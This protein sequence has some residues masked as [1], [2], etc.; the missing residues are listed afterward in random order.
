MS[1]ALHVLALAPAA[2]LALSASATAQYS[3][4][5]NQ[6]PQGSPGNSSFSE[7]LDFSDID[8]DGDMDALFADGGD[9][10]NDRNRIW[11]NQGGLQGGTI[12]FFTD[13][14]GAR[15]PTGGDTSRDVDFVDIDNDGD[16][17]VY[18]S[19]T[20][21][22]SN[23]G[24]RFW[25]NQG[26]MQ[27]GTAGFF[28]DETS[29]R[30]LN[31]GLNNGSSLLSSVASNLAITSGTFQGSFVDWSCDCVFG[32]VDGDGFNDLIHTTYGGVFGGDAPSR[33]FLNDGTGHFEE[34]NPT[35]FQL[36][37]TDIF[38]GDP[39]LWCEG[40]HVN[41]TN[42]TN[43]T[44]CDIS[45][46]PLGV[47]IGDI[48]LDWDI[49]ILQGARNETPRL[50]TN[51]LVETGSVG[52][53]DITSSSLPSATGGGNYEQEI[54]DFD[55]DNDLDLYGLN[56][57]GLSDIT[58]RNNLG[59][60]WG[61][62]VTLSGSGSDDNEGDFLD[63]N[64][65]G[66]LDIFVGN[67]GGSNRLYENDGPP[68]WTF[69]NVSAAELPPDL[70]TALGL[71]TTDIDNDGD[72]D[73]IVANDNGTANQLLVNRNNISD[74][75]APRVVSQ[76]VDDRDPGVEPTAIRA[77]IYDNASWDVSRYNATV[78]EYQ[79][80]GGA[81]QT[82]PMWFVGGQMYYGELAGGLVGTISYTVRSTD[83]TGNAGTSSTKSYAA[84]SLF[85][86]YCTPGTSASGC[87]ATLSATGTPSATAATGFNVIASDVEGDKD[88]LFFYGINGQQAN[89]WGTG[90]SFQC[91]VPPVSRAGLQL[92]SGTVGLC[93][94]GF[95]QDLNA[96]W[97]AKPL[98][99]P[100]AGAVVQTQLWYRDPLNTSSKSTSLSDAIE[101][102]MQP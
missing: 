62:K 67:F 8:G 46:T 5:P 42:N 70:G 101:Y 63:Y 3:N 24:N 96:R 23:Q 1:R 76:Q 80:N 52:F 71:D 2:M 16:D 39:G 58:A 93:D 59:G 66:L 33:L 86:N 79:V 51:R 91:V 20:S 7:N 21:A 48:D 40:N 97:T 83:P 94:G 75:H 34:F 65:D 88:G 28:T 25:V 73:I 35:G 14:T 60:N 74:T 26:G 10:C 54:G 44:N 64:A 68:N 81:V 36:G 69:T 30:W 18:V 56:W 19:N 57:A 13:D 49:D 15:L 78:I 43:G 11:I 72:Q 95:S 85:A 47:E 37:G 27:G 77:R 82:A 100:G 90:T 31:V 84:G 92:A 53:R 98:Q 9:C 41:G 32:D 4:G 38:N 29:T 50:Y 6:I 99:A 17:D 89:Q 45:D 55:N 102:T 87:N 61:P 12:G 22:V